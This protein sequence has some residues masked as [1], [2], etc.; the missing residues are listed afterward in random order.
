MRSPTRALMIA[1]LATTCAALAQETRPAGEGWLGVVKGENV[2][3]RSGPGESY[4]CAKLSAPQTVYVVGESFGWLKIVP[5]KG[6]YSLI[7][8]KFATAD[9][10]IGTITGD[11][12]LV[13]AGSELSPTRMEAVQTRLSTGAKVAII[14]EQADF[15]KIAPPP[16]AYLWMSSQF[17]AKADEATAAKVG[18]TE[19]QP[20]GGNGGET[21][22]VLPKPPKPPAEVRKSAASPFEAA[23]AKLK[24]EFDKPREQRNLQQLL[25]DYQAIPLAADDPLAPLVAARVQFLTDEVA[26]LKDRKE[27]EDL[28]GEVNKLVAETRKPLIDLPTATRPTQRYAAE[29]VLAASNLFK[30]GATGPKRYVINDPQSRLVTAFVQCTSGAVDLEKNVG[31]YVGVIGTSKF[32]ESLR[33]YVVDAEHVVVIRQGVR[34]PTAPKIEPLVAPKSEPGSAAPKPTLEPAPKAP[35]APEKPA[36]TPGPAT[37]KAAPAAPTTKPAAEGATPAAETKPAPVKGLPVAEPTTQPAKVNS[38][39]YD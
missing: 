17:V 29:G 4:P 16:G 32:D 22:V 27:V 19:T 15:Y 23:E 34:T 11:D 39:E 10:Q 14:G 33:M 2:Y 30:G 6:C 7:S 3:V 20:A 21:A 12:V 9:G 24:S 31:D 38:A 18:A 28:L 36:P 26:L 8:K 13:R 5:P 35:V 25:K 1:V 37:M